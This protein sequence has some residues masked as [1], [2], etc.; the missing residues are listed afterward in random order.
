MEEKVHLIITGD[1]R[2]SRAVVMTEKRLRRLIRGGLA[3]TVLF[4]VFTVVSV[5]TL[6]QDHSRQKRM[7]NLESQ[8]QWLNDQNAHLRHQVNRQR[9]EKKELISNAVNHLNERSTQIESLL[10]ES[11]VLKSLP[12]RVAP[13]RK[14]VVVLTSQP[15]REILTMPCFIPVNCLNLPIRCL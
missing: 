10:P 8:V 13:V 3:A 4:T 2:D 9:T 6:V 15:E 1:N 5:Y 12:K 14:A 7:A 11:G